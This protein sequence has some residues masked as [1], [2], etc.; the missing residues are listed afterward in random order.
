[1]KRRLV[2]GLTA[3]VLMVAAAG[4]A[5][6]EPTQPQNFGQC[7]AFISRANPVGPVH[8]EFQ[9]ATVLLLNPHGEDE[10][11]PGPNPTG[12]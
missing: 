2:A 3:G 11:C 8:G 12:S 9:R 10:A 5:S 4:G 7:A 1:M 6:A